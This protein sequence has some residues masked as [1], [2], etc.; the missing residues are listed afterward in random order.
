MIRRSIGFIV[1][2]ATLVGTG[3]GT[4]LRAE[5]I[6]S[7]CGPVLVAQAGGT[8]PGELQPRYQPVPPEE[9]SWYNSSYIFAFTRGL[10][11]STLHPVAKAPLFVLA[12]PFDVAFLPFAAIGG[13]FG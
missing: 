12:I 13:L 10:A 3:P 9:E 11:G 7:A 2:V 1:L 6:E 5:G 8:T 4:A